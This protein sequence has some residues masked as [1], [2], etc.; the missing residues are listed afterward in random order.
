MLLSDLNMLLE[1]KKK[2]TKLLKFQTW[3]C[4][5]I[6]ITLLAPVVFPWMPLEN[7]SWNLIENSADDL[8][9]YFLVLNPG[10]TLK[11]KFL[12]LL[13]ENSF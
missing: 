8:L 13:V 5:F 10:I 9:H 6:W 1:K 12:K 7:D 2:T 11:S 3:P 4:S